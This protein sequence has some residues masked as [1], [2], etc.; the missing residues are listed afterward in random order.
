M[1]TGKST[2]DVAAAKSTA[3]AAATKSTAHVATT[4]AAA[5]VAAAAT[6]ATTTAA[7]AS[8]CIS[9]N[10]G[11]PQSDDR[12]N[13]THLAQH[14]ILHFGQCVRFSRIAGTPRATARWSDQELM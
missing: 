12:K 14:D 3:D 10:R 11:R 8:E 1:S 6:V 9:L 13:D 5:H 2:A 7:T 4:E